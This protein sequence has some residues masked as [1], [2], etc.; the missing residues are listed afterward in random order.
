MVRMKGTVMTN[1]GSLVQYFTAPT[2]I[3]IAVRRLVLREGYSF[4][5][6]RSILRA[7]FKFGRRVHFAL[8]RKMRKPPITRVPAIL[9]GSTNRQ[10]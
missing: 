10:S 2:F 4:R 3:Q 7:A 6:F 5:P 9:N 8:R 1:A